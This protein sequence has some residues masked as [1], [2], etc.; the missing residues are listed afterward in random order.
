MVIKVQNLDQCL[1]RYG[2]LEKIDDAP[3]GRVFTNVEYAIY[4]EYGFTVKKKDGT[5]VYVPPQSFLRKGLDMNK[6]LINKG[7]IQFMKQ[8]LK[9][10]KQKV[11]LKPFMQ[12]VTA[13]VQK[14]AKQ[15]A[16]VS[17]RRGLQAPKVLRDRPR[18]KGQGVGGNLKRSIRREVI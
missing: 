12:Y 14:T 2:L 3:R 15:I 5:L 1:K 18:V 9:N 4:Q 16:P 10:K 11:T 8:S 13:M 6:E 17:V 7:L